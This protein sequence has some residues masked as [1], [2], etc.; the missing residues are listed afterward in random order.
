MIEYGNWDSPL[1]N[2]WVSFSERLIFDY[3]L[4]H[5]IP[6]ATV[7]YFAAQGSLGTEVQKKMEASFLAAL[8]IN[9]LTRMTA[10]GFE[11]LAG[12]AEICVNEEEV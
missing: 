3:L 4:F 2:S 9:I 10:E 11:V 6:L 12:F 7:I 8:R 5:L 1:I